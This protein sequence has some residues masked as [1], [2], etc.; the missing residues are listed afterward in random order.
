MA[1]KQRNKKKKSRSSMPLTGHLREMRNRIAVCAVVFFVCCL[2][3][4]TFS[5]RIV[6]V[7][8]DMGIVYGYS[9]VYLAPQELLMQYLRVTVVAALCVCSPL[10]LYEV[11]AFARPGLTRRENVSVALGLLFGLIC[12]AVGVIFAYK[13]ILPFMLHFLIGLS[14]NSVVTASISVENYISFLLTVF[15]IFGCVFEMPVISLLLTRFGILKPQIMAKSRKVA[16]VLIFIL[17]AV[18]TPPDILS[19][20]M[21]GI[22]MIVLYEFSIIL[23]R[24]MYHFNKRKEEALLTENET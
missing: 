2:I 13:I 23:C 9:Y 1:D 21:V 15:I 6:T 10:I 19:Q 20:I 5:D 4:L 18:I 17:A 11:W 3:F 22:P 7:L 14:A 8:T 24:I 16:I 12:F